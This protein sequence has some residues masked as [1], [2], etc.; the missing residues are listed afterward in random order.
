MSVAAVATIE[1][2]AQ[3][4]QGRRRVLPHGV[5]IHSGPFLPEDLR[6]RLSSR[7]G[8]SF[9][10]DDPV[11]ARWRRMTPATKV[12]VRDDSGSAARLSLSTCAGQAL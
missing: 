12:R 3:A 11:E 5:L 6:G 4:D 9:R 2:V 8:F 7:P 1:L 10:Q